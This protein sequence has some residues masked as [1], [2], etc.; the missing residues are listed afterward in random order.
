M[1]RRHDI[2]GFPDK[3]ETNADLKIVER[4]HEF[5]KTG[6]TWDGYR[7]WRAGIEKTGTIVWCPLGEKCDEHSTN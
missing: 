3:I 6:M 1:E 7:A 2:L 4:G 5:I